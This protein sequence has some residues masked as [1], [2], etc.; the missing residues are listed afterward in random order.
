MQETHSNETDEVLW[1]KEWG[2]KIL[3]CHGTNHSRG[4]AI[5][6][7]HKINVIINK[8]SVDGNGRSQTAH[9]LC[10]ESNIC[11]INIYAP[12]QDQ[13]NEQSTFIQALHDELRTV[14]L[15]NTVIGGDFNL[16]LNGKLDKY[17]GNE[18][19]SKVSNEM[20]MMLDQLDLVDIWR[21]RNPDNRRYT[22]R[23]S[24]PLTQSRLDYWLI[25]QELIYSVDICD[26]KPS[27]KTDHSLITLKIKSPQDEKRGPGIWKFNESLLNDIQFVTELKELITKILNDLREME[28]KSIKWEMIKMEIRKKCILYSKE[29]A[30]L[31]KKF[32]KEMLYRY[33]NLN[34]MIDSGNSTETVL[35]QFKITKQEIENINAYRTEG[36]RIRAKAQ[37]I[38]EGEKCTSFFLRTEHRN[39]CVK[40]VTKLYKPDGNIATSGKEIREIQTTFYKKLY[41]EHDR[42]EEFDSYIL[43]DLLTLSEKEIKV[44]QDIKTLKNVQRL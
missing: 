23:R 1:Q 4:V 24:H 20:N 25:P 36:A 21:V 32:E 42:A 26:I 15:Q 19:I 38:E 6:F 34:I 29:K 10:N 5:L 39:Y 37:E 27:I 2:S 41:D 13:I 14:D 3:F 16:Y 12:T 43:K 9:L 28:N 11:I 35:E 8:Y 22:W 7:P 44:C 33:E 31:T 18:H 30:Y 40:N 17:M